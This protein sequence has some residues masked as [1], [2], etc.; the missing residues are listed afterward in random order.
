MVLKPCPFCRKEIPRAMTVCPYCHM[1]EKGKPVRIDSSAPSQE[2]TD[3]FFENDLK[4]LSSED[5]FVC[6]QAVIRIA[7]RGFGVVQA[8]I[9]ILNDLGKPGLSGVAKALGRIGDRRAIAVLSQAARSGDEELRTAAIWALAQFREPEVLPVLLTEAE[10]PHPTIQAYLAYVLG[11]YQ[12][13]RVVPV[14]GALCR[15]HNREVAFQA[16]YALGETGSR[17]ALP[18]LRRV[19]KRREPMIREAA[20]ASL[21]R[22]GASA[23]AAR[24]GGWVYVIV[25]VVV[26]ALGAGGWFFLHR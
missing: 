3:R 19:L 14:L 24:A 12:D 17:N 2:E 20:I 22:L 26:S 21:R 15:H 11:G 4:D 5:P 1:D 25:G 9:S 6:E 7:Q 13:E 23:I 8:L 16:A 18:S 10:R